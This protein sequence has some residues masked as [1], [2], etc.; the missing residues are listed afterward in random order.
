VTLRD[1][2]R[3]WWNPGKWRDEHPDVS[4]GEG[5]FDAEQRLTERV[6][7]E[8]QLFSKNDPGDPH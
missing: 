7:A 4:D 2:F 3:R 1:R 5:F 8:R 6:V